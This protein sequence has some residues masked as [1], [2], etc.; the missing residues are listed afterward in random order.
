MG[1]GERRTLQFGRADDRHRLA[2]ER[3]ERLDLAGRVGAPHGLLADRPPQDVHD[4]AAE[5]HAVADE[6]VLG[7]REAG[8]D[9]TQGGGRR[10]G[11]HGV[12]RAAG[13]RRQ[14]GHQMTMRLE[15]I[16]SEPVEHEQHGLLG[17]CR[18]ASG[19]SRATRSP[20]VPGR[21]APG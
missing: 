17:V 1:F 19:T 9:R 6:S 21:A 8:G 10:G 14:R 12:D 4:L 5:H 16:P 3:L 18:P 2:E 11:R 15:L 20:R 13:H 7:R